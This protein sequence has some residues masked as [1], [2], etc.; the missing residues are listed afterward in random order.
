[1]LTHNTL[2]YP[3]QPIKPARKILIPQLP[4]SNKANEK[5]HL[6][7]LTKSAKL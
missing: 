2:K 4:T 5:T 3:E 1:M 7:S 6:R